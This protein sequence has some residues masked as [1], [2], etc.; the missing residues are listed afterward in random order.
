MERSD[1]L[2]A[3]DQAE[4]PLVLPSLLACDFSRVGDELTAL[5]EAGTAA[6]HLDVM[7]G[8][9]VSNLTYGPPVIADWRRSTDLPFD[10]HLMIS[11]PA[12]HVGAFLDAGCDL[13]L[14]HIEVMP[15]PTELLRTV[16]RQGCRAGL[17]LNPPTPVESV[18]P[19]LTEVDRVLV[20]SVTPGQGGQAFDEMVLAK[21]RRLRRERAGLPIVID[22]GI[23]PHTAELATQA[24]VTELVVGSYFFQN[25]G[26]YA[27][28]LAEVVGAARRGRERGGFPAHS[29]GVPS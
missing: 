27:T 3:W 1:R 16:R 23:K 11:D 21:V 20:M 7:D 24:G 2:E 10:A 22:G 13:I 8:H 9:F 17:V 5:R 18:L 14:F 28:A 6:V 15:E 19:Y 29:A 12:R 26:H 25:H 4:R